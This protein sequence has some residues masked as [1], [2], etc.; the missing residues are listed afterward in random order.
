[1]SLS[2]HHTTKNKLFVVSQDVLYNVTSGNVLHNEKK[3]HTVEKKS[4]G[5]KY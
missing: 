4:R 5:E 1:M 3:K 2:E